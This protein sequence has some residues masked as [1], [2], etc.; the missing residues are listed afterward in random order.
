MRFIREKKSSSSIS[1]ALSSSSSALSFSRSQVNGAGEAAKQHDRAYRQVLRL[2]IS[3]Q[4]LL[5]LG[6][7]LPVL[8]LG[9]QEHLL[10]EIQHEDRGNDAIDKAEDYIKPAEL[11]AKC[12]S[13]LG[14]LSASM[15]DVLETQPKNKNNENSL[16]SPQE[17]GVDNGANDGNM[18]LSEK[19]FLRLQRTTDALQPKWEEVSNRLHARHIFGSEASAHNLRTFD[20]TIFSQVEAMLADEQKNVERSRLP[21]GDSERL[22]K[23]DEEA[24]NLDDE[25]GSDSG[26]ESD[27][28]EARG[29]DGSSSDS[30]SSSEIN[31]SSD[32]NS[33]NGSD[34]GSRSGRSNESTDALF[35]GM[36]GSMGS[37]HGA[38]DYDLE[39]YD[40]RQ[41][42]SL[43]LKRF[44]ASE[45]DGTVHGCSTS[46]HLNICF[47]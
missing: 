1:L 8:T 12:V 28:E 41:L 42:Y 4:Q 17:N 47:S 37:M 25:S 44:I 24:D 3:L 26:D 5:D 33:S 32:S 46:P 22:G 2:R 9:Q 7:R 18:D 16:E 35:S 36:H 34:S 19:L 30:N 15:I 38:G 40:D 13:L 6:N 14:N 43:L 10:K 29:S 23:D 21:W 31:S 39:T 27:G 45:G 20:H 11:H